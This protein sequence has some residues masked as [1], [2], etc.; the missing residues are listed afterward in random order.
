MRTPTQFEDR[1]ITYKIGLAEGMKPRALLLEIEEP[2]DGTSSETTYVYLSPTGA[3][4]M[5]EALQAQAGVPLK[6][7]VKPKRRVRK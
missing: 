7:R 3:L 2:C 5:A 4:R 1:G 6:T